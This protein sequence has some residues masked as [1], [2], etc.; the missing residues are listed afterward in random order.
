MRKFSKHYRFCPRCG[1]KLI[2]N[3]GQKFD[4][5]TLCGFELYDS[6]LAG[7]TII[8]VNAKGEILLTKRARSPKKGMWGT[9]G[10]FTERNENAEQAARREV[11]EELDT[12]LPRRLAYF[13]TFPVTYEY[14]GVRYAYLEITFV[15]RVSNA[16]KPKARDD[17]SAAKFFSPTK[18]PYTRLAWSSQRAALRAFLK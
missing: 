17:I 14:Q 18:I 4:T 2:I 7:V 10:G 9:P 8:I 15:A 12:R 6:I 3:R 1:E 16:V 5:C 13:G 11:R